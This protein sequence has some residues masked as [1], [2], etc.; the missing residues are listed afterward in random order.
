MFG[1]ENMSVGIFSAGT[2]MDGNIGND[3]I[4][5]VNP[6]LAGLEEFSAPHDNFSL[7]PAT[8]MLMARIN[9]QVDFDVDHSKYYGPACKLAEV[10]NT[11]V[12][13][14]TTIRHDYFETPLQRELFLQKFAESNQFISDKYLQGQAFIQ[15][16][17]TAQSNLLAEL[18]ELT[19]LNGVLSQLIKRYCKESDKRD[20]LAK[21]IGLLWK[22]EL[23][24]ML[25]KE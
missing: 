3:F 4:A 7:M 6:N 23:Q 25:N 20:G 1:I 22:D 2:L 9:R 17:S 18:D 19:L 8:A 21:I 5:R 13:G 16:S 15:D 24:R 11:T 12:M 10:V 14:T